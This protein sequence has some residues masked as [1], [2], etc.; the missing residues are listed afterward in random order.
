MINLF[1]IILFP[2]ILSN[3][4]HMVIV[5]I[6]YLRFLSIPISTRLF[7]INKTW[8]GFVLVPVINSVLCWLICLLA[9][10][11]IPVKTLLTG[12]ILGVFYMLFEL[13]NSFLKRRF[14]ISSGE[15]ANGIKSLFVILDKTDSAFGVSLISYFL[16]NL[17]FYNF[18][19]LFF[20]SVFIHSSFSYLLVLIGV[21]RSF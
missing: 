12:F 3:I 4:I 7:G 17:S 20:I 10:Y 18:I 5:K 15:K 6:N 13:P 14:G 1:V 9:N 19:I 2:L 8:R 21:K 11:E 16:F